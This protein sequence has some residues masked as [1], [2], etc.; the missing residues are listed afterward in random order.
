MNNKAASINA[1]WADLMVEEL[2][3]NQV[4]CFCL[5]PG[6]RCTPLTVAA[7]SNKNV[8]AT[9]HYDERGA[10]YH[11]LGYARASGKPAVLVCTSGTA[12]ANYLPAV[13]EASMDMV[14]M[15][16]LSSD[17]P[18]ELHESGANQTID[19]DRLFGDYA[20]WWCNLPCP[21]EEIGPRFVLT[22]V[23]QAAY[24]TRRAPAGP[25]HIN[26]MFREPLAAPD[27]GPDFGAYLEGVKGWLDSGAP[28][29]AYGQSRNCLDSEQLKQLAAFINEEDSGFLVVGRLTDERE[30]EAVLGLSRR[31]GWPTLPD[32]LSG[33]R[34]GVEDDHIVPYYELILLAEMQKNMSIRSVVHIGGQVTSKKLLQFLGQAPLENY[35]RIANHPYRHDPKHSVTL[36]IESDIAEACDALRAMLK[37]SMDINVL[38]LKEQSTAVGKI[39]NDLVLGEALNGPAVVRLVSRYVAAEAA[40]FVANSL[41]VREMDW[42]AEPRGHRVPVGC[43]RGASGIDGTIAS[44]VGFA[45]GYNRQVTLLIGDLAA[46]HDLNSLALVKKSPQPLVIV[47]INNN[48]G[49]LFSFLPIARKR[50]QFEPYFGTPH[51]LTFENAAKMFQVGYHRPATQQE[52]VSMYNAAQKAGH[53]TIIEVTTDRAETMALHQRIFGGVV[54]ALQQG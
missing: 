9:M 28:Y 41:A 30:R 25:V 5:S 43:N 23:D 37:P 45:R 29:T 26:C 35:I 31:L 46:L 3:R 21:T 24:R 48:G 19:Q 1:V 40:L 50:E 49:G 10:A 42:F 33:L 12:V 20:R 14:P 13:V 47:I 44:A 2:V 54:A 32:V 15:V 16:I 27:E 22:T 34:L 53:S 18:P 11:A 39:I 6:S 8:D 36:R 38:A 17:R 4:N 52:F 51:D 7:A